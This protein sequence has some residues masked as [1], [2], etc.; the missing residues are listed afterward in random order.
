MLDNRGE[1]VEKKGFQSYRDLE[2]YQIAH[3]LAIKL[4]GFSLS[5]PKYELFES[6]SQLRRASKSITANIVE[7]FGRRRYKADFIRYLVY[8]QASLDETVEWV[9]TIRDCHKDSKFETDNFLVELDKLGRKLNR[10]ILSVE[11]SHLTPK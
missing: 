2:I 5:L 9:E 1:G 8:A 10:F 11:K 3:S 4:H 7:G 6:G